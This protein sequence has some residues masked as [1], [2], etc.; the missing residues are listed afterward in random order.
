[1]LLRLGLGPA[2]TYLLTV[3]GRRS[4]APRSTPVTLVEEGGRRWLR[5]PHGGVARGRHPA[6]PVRLVPVGLGIIAALQA[7]AATA[8][9]P[10]LTLAVSLAASV[11][12]N[13]VSSDAGA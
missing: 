6:L 11:L 12:G 1:M 5:S 4:G 3:T 9:Y 10:I 8:A 2:R 7:V 13:M